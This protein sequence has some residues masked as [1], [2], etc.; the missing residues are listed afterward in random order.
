MSV[1]SAVLGLLCVGLAAASPL[2][3]RLNLP[4][5]Q[6]HCYGTVIAP[7]LLL[8]AAECAFNSATG[9]PHSNLQFSLST[10]AKIKVTRVHIFPGWLRNKTPLL[11]FAT[12]TLASPLQI[13]ETTLIWSPFSVEESN[14]SLKYASGNI[15]CSSRGQ[16]ENNMEYAANQLAAMSC[17]GSHQHLK[18]PGSP[19]YQISGVSRSAVVFGV[20]VGECSSEWGPLATVPRGPCAARLSHEIFRDICD[21][22]KKEKQILPECKDALQ[23]DVDPKSPTSLLSMAAYTALVNREPE[24]GII[25]LFCRGCNI[26][27]CEEGC[28]SCRQESLERFD[29]LALYVPFYRRVLVARVDADSLGFKVPYAPYILYRLP[30]TLQF[31]E[32]RASLTQ[33]VQL[34]Q[35]DSSGGSGTSRSRTK[36]ML[37]GW[38]AGAARACGSVVVAIGQR[39]VSPFVGQRYEI[40]CTVAE[41]QLR[42]LNGKLINRE[43]K[44][45]VAGK[46]MPVGT[47]LEATCNP[48]LGIKARYPILNSLSLTC[49]DDGRFQPPVPECSGT[50]KLVPGPARRDEFLQFPD[51]QIQF[52][53]DL[54]AP[55][56]Y[57]L[58]TFINAKET[59]EMLQGDTVTFTCPENSILRD[60]LTSPWTCKKNLQKKVFPCEAAPRPCDAL[61]IPHADTSPSGQIPHNSRVT[62][63][64]RDN[65]RVWYS[66]I[67]DSNNGG[68]FDLLDSISLTCKDGSLDSEADTLECR[69]SCDISPPA[70][71]IADKK[72]KESPV[73]ILQTGPGTSRRLKPPARVWIDNQV[74]YECSDREWWLDGTNHNS[75]MATCSAG[76]GMSPPIVHCNVQCLVPLK[77]PAAGEKAVELKRGGANVAGTRILSQQQVEITCPPDSIMYSRAGNVFWETNTNPPRKTKQN[78]CG[79]AGFGFDFPSCVDVAYFS[80]KFLYEHTHLGSR[81]SDLAKYCTNKLNAIVGAVIKSFIVLHSDVQLKALNSLVQSN[82]VGGANIADKSRD[83]PMAL[84]KT[85]DQYEV[86]VCDRTSGSLKTQELKRKV[87]VGFQRS[88]ALWRLYHYH[89]GTPGTAHELV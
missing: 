22:A 19:A 5:K 28:R 30:G 25:L 35:Q 58:R 89:D 80:N 40:R 26:D 53:P 52:T 23:N 11:S 75:Q 86:F 37:P 60:D 10:G 38:V 57:Q 24:Y 6:P 68:R 17:P 31:R 39:L 54:G 20:H 4:S 49:E 51:M 85:K 63:S 46:D 3:G 48:G 59:R 21:F 70:I 77:A 74:L 14:V 42:S 82:Q 65:R 56:T 79:P 50:C 32:H 36:R 67:E 55:Q 69:E 84:Y 73:F 9:R 76:G 43:G 83:D 81:P 8:T 45:V 41:S 16:D 29:R 12:L 7:R 2:V 78:K 34:F 47:V 61:N 15:R 27:T 44:E 87:F 18:I 88:G 33:L 72:L 64:C 66:G 71:A 62:V 13:P 1:G